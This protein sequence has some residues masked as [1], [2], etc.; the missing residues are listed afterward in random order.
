MKNKVIYYKL[1]T[2]LYTDEDDTTLTNE[3]WYEYDTITRREK[4]ITP[5]WAKRGELFKAIKVTTDNFNTLND[6][7]YISEQPNYHKIKVIFE[8]KNKLKWFF[9]ENESCEWLDKITK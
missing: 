3:A 2:T 5:L 8:S 6:F 1:N 9:C 7:Y 4:L